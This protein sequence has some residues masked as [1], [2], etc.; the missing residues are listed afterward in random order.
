MTGIGF[1]YRG[2]LTRLCNGSAGQSLI[3]VALSVPIFVLLL[4]GAAEFGTVL[5][6]AIE[7]SDAARDGAVYGAQ[8]GSTASD[9]TGIATAASNGAANLSGLTTTSSYSCACSDGTSSTCA[10]DDCANSHIE[11]TVTVNTQISFTPVIHLPAIPS[12]FTLKGKAVQ[13][14][15]Q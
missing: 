9:T 15:L 12:T 1:D 11:E 2:L 14:C 8:N 3:E 13:K 6:V 10:V 7:V 4:V 5:Y